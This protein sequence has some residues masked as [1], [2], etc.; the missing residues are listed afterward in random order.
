MQYIIYIEINVKTTK[1][2]VV[3]RKFTRGTIFI[4]LASLIIGLV[5]TFFI[6]GVAKPNTPQNLTNNIQQTQ[7]LTIDANFFG[8][9]YIIQNGNVYLYNPATSNNFSTPNIP[10]ITVAHKQSFNFNNSNILQLIFL[11]DTTNGGTSSFVSDSSNIASILTIEKASDINI[12]LKYPYG[13]AYATTSTNAQYVLGELALNT[14]TKLNYNGAEFIIDKR[15]SASLTSATTNADA[16]IVKLTEGKFKLAGSVTYCPQD[17]NCRAFLQTGG[18]LTLDGPTITGFGVNSFEEENGN[19]VEGTIGSVLYISNGTFNFNGGVI[20]STQE[21]LASEDDFANGGEIIIAALTESSEDEITLN[22]CGGIIGYNYSSGYTIDCYGNYERVNVNCNLTGSSI[23]YNYSSSES[24]IYANCTNL[25]IDGSRIDSNYSEFCLLWDDEGYSTFEMA[26]GVICGNECDDGLFAFRKITITG[27]QVFGNTCSSAIYTG[28]YSSYN[29]YVNISNLEISDNTFSGALFNFDTI[30]VDLNFS[31]LTI[32]DNECTSVFNIAADFESWAENL[33]KTVNIDITGSDITGN[34]CGDALLAIVYN[35]E[36]SGDVT[37]SDCEITSNTCSDALLAINYKEGMSSDIVISGLNVSE[38]SFGSLMFDIYAPDVETISF[39]DLSIIDNESGEMFDTYCNGDIYFDTLTISENDCDGYDM[40]YSDTGR[41]G[42]Y[43]NLTITNNID[44]SRVFYPGQD[45]VILNNIEADGNETDCQFFYTEFIENSLTIQGSFSV[46]NHAIVEEDS[47]E[48]IGV[49]SSI[50]V[51]LSG[52]ISM[53]C[54]DACYAFGIS[55]SIFL[56]TNQLSFVSSDQDDYYFADINFWSNEES[57]INLNTE[58]TSELTVYKEG[59]AVYNAENPAPSYIAYSENQDYLASGKEYITVVNLPEETS[60]GAGLIDN[61]LVCRYNKFTITYSVPKNATLNGETT[62]EYT[63]ET[64][65]TLFSASRSYADFTG[66]QVY[67][68][69]ELGA[70]WAE[71]QII[72]ADNLHVGSGH[73]GNITLSMKYEWHEYR[74]IFD[75][76]GHDEALNEITELNE[77][78]YV[79]YNGTL[80][81]AYFADGT[82]A[83]AELP[84]VDGMIGWAK[85]ADEKTASKMLKFNSQFNEASAFETDT[86]NR[87]FTIYAAFKNM[88]VVLF[89]A[90]ATMGFESQSTN[91]QTEYGLTITLPTNYRDGFNFIGWFD[92]YTGTTQ[93]GVGGDDFFVGKPFVPGDVSVFYMYAQYTIDAGLYDPDT[94]ELVYSWGELISNNM[95]SVD[96]GVLMGNDPTMAGRLVI[97]NTVSSIGAEAFKNYDNLTSVLLSSSVKTI[98]ESAFED[99]DLTA[100]A[101]GGGVETIGSRAFA[102][103]CNLSGTLAIPNSVIT[104]ENNAFFCCCSLENLKLGNSVQTIGSYAF[105]SCC[106]LSGTLTIPDG[107]T[108]IGDY[109]FFC[110]EMLESLVI[111]ENVQTISDAAFADNSSFSGTITIPNNVTSIGEYAFSG[112]SSVTRFKIGTGVEEIGDRAFNGCK[113]LTT[114]VYKGCISTGFADDSNLF[115]SSAENGLEVAITEEVTYIPGNMFYCANVIKLSLGSNV[116]EIGYSAFRENYNFA[117]ELHIPDSVVTIGDNAFQECYPLERMTLG[118]NVEYIGDNAFYECEFAGE[119]TIP[120]SVTYIGDYAFYYCINID[121]ELIIPD[122][123]TYIGDYAFN[124]CGEID[125]LTLGESV[126][127]IGEYAFADCNY[128]AGDLVIPDSVT[129]IGEYAFAWC[130]HLQG[131]TLGNGLQHIADYAF[132]SMPSMEESLI[133]PD[134]VVSIGKAAFMENC[135]MGLV[136]GKNLETIGSYAFNECCNLSGTLTIPDSVTYIGNNAFDCCCSIETL[137]LGSSI[138]TIG[139]YAFS[140]L[141]SVSGTVT[142]PN[143]VTS[144]GESAFGCCEYLE[145]LIYNGNVTTDFNYDSYVFSG[146]GSSLDPMSCEVII[147]DDVTYIPAWMFTSCWAVTSLTIGDNVETV[148]E[149]AF[150]YCGNVTYLDLGSG[151][152]NIGE[153]AFGEFC[154]L[155]GTLTIP[156]SVITIGDSAFYCMCGVTALEIGSGLA[157]LGTNSFGTDSLETIEVDSANTNFYSENHCLIRTAD[158]VLVT[159]SANSVIPADVTA[160]AYCA[161]V[162]RQITGELTIPASV[163]TIGEY[164]FQACS[165]L[166]KINFLGNVETIEYDAF[167][168]CDNILEYDFTHCTDVPAIGEH[169]FDGINDDC[170][171]YVPPTLYNTWVNAENWSTWKDHIITMAGLY[172][173]TTGELVYSWQELLDNE[174]ISVENGVL[175]GEDSAALAGSLVIDTSVTNIGQGAFNGYTGL[176]AVSIPASVTNIEDSAFEGCT[177]LIGELVL[178]AAIINIGAS[179]FNGCAGFTGDLVIPN[180]VTTIGESAF[181]GCSGFNGQLVLSNKLISIS[182]S[183]F[184]NCSGLTGDL[185]IP[186]GITTIGESA[187]YGCGGLTG[188]L[189]LPEELTTIAMNTFRN[190]SSLTSVTIPNRV[191]SV[192]ECAFYDCSGLTGELNIPN[193]TITIADAAFNGCRN[194]TNLVLGSAVQY[195]GNSAFIGCINLTGALNIPDSVISV[196]PY[197]FQR[198]N[199]LTSVTIGDSVQTIGAG[200]FLYCEGLTSITISNAVT[201]MGNSVFYGCSN[202]LKYDFTD[203]TSVP[204]LGTDA[205]TGI[206][207][208][209]KIYVPDALYST[210]KEETNWSTWKDYIASDE[211]FYGLFDEN[212]NRTLSWQQLLD[213]GYVTVTNGELKGNNSALA[214]KLVIPKTVT[215]IGSSA[216]TGNYALKSVVIGSGVTSIGSMAF[217]G[218]YKLAEVYNLSN[219]NIVAGSIDH[220]YVA[221]Y[222][223]VVY[224][225]LCESEL[226]TDANGY[227]TYTGGTDVI[228]VDYIGT[229]T[230]LNFPANITKVRPG[231]FGYNTNITSVVMGDL[232]TT[233]GAQAF[234]GCSNLTSITFGDG[235][236]S[237]GG[238]AFCS[239]G[240]TSFTLPKGVTNISGS[241]FQNCGKLQS[242]YVEEGNSVYH[243]ENNCIIKTST[244]ELVLGCKNSTIPNYVTSIGWGAFYSNNQLT[245]ITIPSSVTSIGGSAFYGCTG[246]TSVTIPNSVTSI[247]NNAFAYCSNVLEFDFSNHASVP[248]LGTDV[249][250]NMNSACKIYVPADL[251][252]TWIAAT[253]WSTYRK[254]IFVKPHA[255]TTEYGLF[256]T[257]TGLQILTWEQLLSSG[258]VTVSN[259]ALTGANSAMAGELRISNTITSIANSAFKN[260][261]NLTGV[262]IPDSVTTIGGDAFYGCTGVIKYE[263]VYHTQIPELGTSVFNNINSNCKIYVPFTLYND[264]IAADNWSTWADYIEPMAGLYNESTGGLIY[265]WQELLDNNYIT[266]NNG[267]LDGNSSSALAGHLVISNDVTNIGNSAFNG[268]SKLTRVTIP[269]SVTSIGNSAFSGCSGLTSLTIGSGVT[270]IG[271]RAFYGCTRVQTLTYNGNVTTDFTSSSVVFYNLGQN[272][273]TGTC[274]VIIGD[275]VTTIPAYMF[276]DYCKNITSVTIGNSVE[277][278]GTYAFYGCSNLTNLTLGNSVETIGSIAF[279]E[280]SGLTSLTIPNSVTT[281]GNSAFYGCSGLISVTIPSSVTSI[282]DSAFSYCSGLTSVTI[283]NSVTSIG[284]YAF[285]GCTGVQTLTYNGNVT[286]DFTNNSNVFY[287]LGQNSATGICEVIIGDNVTTIPAYMFY[288]SN[289]SYRPRITGLTIGTSVTTIGNYAFQN[290][291]GLT[292][293]TIPNSVTS[294]GTYA[295]QNC[296]GV[297]TLIYN[298]NVTTDFTGSSNLFNNLGQNST[299][300]KCEVIIGDNVTTIPA[301]MFYYGRY[302]TS[303]TIGN[304]VETIGN[305]AFQNCSGLTSLTIPNSVTSIGN[306]AFQNCSGLTSVTIPNSITTIGECAF[307]V[308][309]GVQTLTYNGN[310]TTDPTSNQG[311]FINIGQNSATGTCEVIIGD[312]VT[313]IPAYMFY[314]DSYITSLTIGNCVTTIGNYAFRG[315]S[316]LTSI[317]IPSSVTSIGNEAFYNCT[318]VQT[319]T[320]N[321]NVTTDFAIF[322]YVFYNLGQNSATGKCEVIIGDNVTTIPA[323]MFCNDSYITSVTIGNSVETIGTY[324]FYGCSGLTSITIPNSVTSIGNCAFY[325]CAGVQTL[326]YNG[327]VTTDFTSNSNVFYN[328]G[329]N[330][331]TGKCEVIIGDNVTTIPAYMFYV[332][333]SS[334]RPRITGL[335]IGNSVTSIGN[336]AFRNCSGLTSLTIGSGVTCIGTYAF[337]DCSSVTSITIPSSVTSIGNYAFSG[338]T[339]LTSLTIG[340][341]VTSIGKSA[342]SGCT[343]VQTLTYNGN[344]TTDFTINDKVFYNL[345]QNSATGT[346]EVIIG[347]NVTTIPAYMFYSSYITSVII[348]NSV[349][350]IGTYAFYDCSSVTSITI[351]NSVTTIGNSAFS[352]CSGLTSVTIGNSVETIGSQAFNSC[353]KLAEVYNLSNLNIVAGSTSYGYVAYYAFVV[354]TQLGESQLVTDANGYVT[355]T[356]ETDIILVDYIGTDTDLI[357]PANITKIKAGAFYNNT[358]ITSVVMGDLVTTIG[359][360]AFNDC[361]NLTSITFG[362][363]VTSISGNAFCSSGLTSFTLPKGVTSI[364]GYEFQRCSN[365]QSLY[366]EEGNTVYHSENNCIIKTS[367]NELVL[368]CENSTIPSYVTS[369][370]SHAFNNRT[371]L[372]SITIPNSVTSIGDS[373]FYYC[374]GLTSVTIGS[375]VASIGSSAFSSCSGLTSIIIPNSVTSIGS[376]AFYYCTGL[377]SVIIGNSVETIGNQAFRNCSG[378]TSIFIPSSVITISASSYSNS[379][380]YNCSSTMVIYCEVSEA[381]SGWA[382]YWNYRASGTT[383][384]T[385]YGCTRD[386]DGNI[387]DS[388]N[389]LVVSATGVG[390]SGSELVFGEMPMFGNGV[391]DEGEAVLSALVIIASVCVGYILVYKANK[392]AAAKTA[393]RS[394]NK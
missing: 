136:L 110:C 349:E 153:N 200:A 130:E 252:D 283:P 329:Q 327:N 300:G 65:L 232:V 156:D 3:V 363:G 239:S 97:A 46:L 365:L 106:N 142:I 266:V 135:M 122:S 299:T 391:L 171:I 393:E 79:R 265:S 37:F 267:E 150:E 34:T 50:N 5:C 333:N 222:A 356:T 88:T 346:C 318:G 273:A 371:G 358:N 340:S 117:G 217:L 75:A 375:G 62:V 386:A 303:L 164:S 20:G 183:T 343:G 139:D 192:G 131:L 111:G 366:V 268:Y 225:E 84:L 175:K 263:L 29:D 30:G 247:G 109:A 74:I 212:G 293:I 69:D 158:K 341:D 191:I 196:G 305:S 99:S 344:V 348:G 96:N 215:T 82:L 193:S 57:L 354:Y 369:I 68:A 245:S 157:N 115:E 8:E 367:T 373:A 339:G 206:N 345:G 154:S 311:W 255:P 194:L 13:T 271:E 276:F 280:C 292:S 107:V 11:K 76:N 145:Q 41:N 66:W 23:Q 229:D 312:N 12:E 162:G 301:Y 256:E 383:L 290:C 275:N 302:I 159:G 59:I 64:D 207:S 334:Y 264:W 352:G 337:Y 204:T 201:E 241:T 353:Y 238:N 60:L 379:P 87:T 270:S 120:D 289:S 240:L 163:V 144:I 282:G 233:I 332:S 18:E 89:D 155:Q 319:L 137:N 325:G 236:T 257:D 309:T 258:R 147:G 172:N 272:S 251:Y 261:T 338:C 390:D 321:G 388:N 126:E 294:I 297:Q 202:V 44:C 86:E 361:S 104:I 94:N 198:C 49:D 188:S 197:A 189:T 350:T 33:D 326:T 317:T 2:E 235:V 385:H 242:L 176:T 307:D 31:G 40:F 230:D 213:Q 253:N 262:V 129:S 205:F 1:E 141:C 291:S 51:Y 347:D 72:S 355:Y 372:T 246:L 308:C 184:Y 274:E 85:K 237:I 179:A 182:N 102:D 244:N 73:Y 4:S 16:Q 298:G 35:E 224:Q 178:P 288:V 195:I 58:L 324:A 248:T 174:Y 314:S 42:Y 331:A 22:L 170:K 277:T 316:G 359:E 27:G 19:W 53:D 149:S 220:G 15:G 26:S 169:V 306:Y 113:N 152:V 61:Y 380:F 219:L 376:S 25:K 112:C 374:S 81:K 323:Y 78:I 364:S 90:D 116:E 67:L 70:S 216:F 269:S 148:G 187:F 24:V 260:Y 134:S 138:E 285:K 43:E 166:T 203:H 103:C 322:S 315:C 52:N 234:D 328:L 47:Y 342:F 17:P 118:E 287:N 114:F 124:Y 71:G 161:F 278:I 226:V 254:N 221:Y 28:V 368:G 36:M 304:S 160:I 140:S 39:E 249:F 93:Y 55:G 250:Q 21:T 133:I 389:N 336:Y 190:C 286:T 38:N 123:V 259:G 119:L 83:F 223:A 296:T 243:A 173:S 382:T 330:S 100:V 335:T 310:V 211:I 101:L 362:A 357:L 185:V 181:N 384:T 279:Y 281:I 48:L 186:D 177:G 208:A 6:G 360:Q 214:G 295:F 387:Y 32:T 320:Y 167:S 7:Q 165:N 14:N 91:I 63:D 370:R 199:G 378:L 209:C 127:I 392:K 128:I 54:S 143:S 210:W 313:T 9:Q 56:E 394:D 77:P 218:C 125:Y 377:T 92:S 180:S 80:E 10:T 168:Y 227:I 108:N 381:P 228:L 146:I 121:G 231:A 105:A 98:G 45:D 284:N 151:V 132:Y 95:I 351:P